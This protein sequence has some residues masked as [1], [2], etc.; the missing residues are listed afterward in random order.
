[1]TR[2]FDVIVVGAG[3][4]GLSAAI[5]AARE[6]LSTLV[7]ERGE[8]VGAK[9][10]TGGMILA[11]SL[12]EV[13]PEFW[14]EAPLERPILSQRIMMVS[15]ERFLTVEIGN[16]KNLQPPYNG[17]SVLRHKFDAW[18]ADYARRM[19][20]VILEGTVVDDL[21]YENGRVVGV[22]TRRAEGNVYGN[23]VILADGV[24]SLLARR[25]GLRKDFVSHDIGLGVKELLALPEDVISDRFGVR[26]GVGASYSVL[27]SFARGIPG[28]G[29]I[30][31]NKD[32]ISIG[33][34]LQPENI[35]QQ[36]LTPDDVLERFKSVPEIAR[37]IEG[38]KLVEY[39]GHLLAEGGYASMPKLHAA[40]ILVAG[41]A[42]GFS[43]NTGIVLQG[44]NLAISSG[45][46]A[47]ETAIEACRKG[48]FSDQFLA[49]YDEHLAS[50]QAGSSM[51]VHKRAPEIM[52][53]PRMFDQYPDMINDILEQVVTVGPGTQELLK[54]IAMREAKKVGI[55][56]IISDVMTGVK[57]L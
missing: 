12:A 15:D 2:K 29:F 44:I 41:D 16:E 17:F 23:V 3:P 24:N 6:G 19:G 10:M 38:A 36:K 11:Q 54:N 45:R 50:C 22:K 39:S 37:L 53:C 18:M 9:N 14:N 27:G 46:C 7:L 52:S 5:V 35:C 49:R 32:T 42:G 21:I 48:D 1:M 47:A 40:G 26:N 51:K 31:T 30:Y 56:N 20:A 57:A 4:A 33:V 43:C 34:V 28:G 25:A 8:Y 13:V 55:K